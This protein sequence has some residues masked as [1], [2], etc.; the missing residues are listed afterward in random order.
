[1]LGFPL[2]RQSVLVGNTLIEEAGGFSLV[3]LRDPCC[4]CKCPDGQ[5]L[6]QLHWF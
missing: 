3:S 5:H 2:E 1:M 4:L 6:N